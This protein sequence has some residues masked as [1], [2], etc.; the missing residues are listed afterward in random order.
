MLEQ[1]CRQT[2]VEIRLKCPVTDIGRPEKFTVATSQGE[3]RSES[4]VIATGGLSYSSLGASGF[5]YEVAKKFGLKVTQL[6]RRWYLSSFRSV[7]RGF[8]K[9]WQ[10]SP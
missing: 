3:H 6:S 7:T 5:G 4:L 10:A 9:I 2:G 8:S 1:E